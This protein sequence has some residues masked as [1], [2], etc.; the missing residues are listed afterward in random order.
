MD[1]EKE[2]NEMEIVEKIAGKEESAGRKVRI[3]Y[4]KIRIGNS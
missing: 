2:K 3:G 1:V 4:G